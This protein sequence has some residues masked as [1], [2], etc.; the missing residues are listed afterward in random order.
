MN[1]SLKPNGY[2]INPKSFFI[3]I[4][5][6]I[7]STVHFIDAMRTAKEV[8]MPVRF[9]GEWNLL[10]GV[11]EH[12]NQFPDG[13]VIHLRP[14]GGLLHWPEAVLWIPSSGD[15]AGVLS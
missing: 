13:Q 9:L 14:T 10:K 6:E 15:P 7:L 5:Q 3:G 12:I 11:V 8:C 4:R 2:P 1:R